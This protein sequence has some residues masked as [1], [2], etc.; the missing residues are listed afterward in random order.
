[1][2]YFTGKNAYFPFTQHFRRQ[3]AHESFFIFFNRGNHEPNSNTVVV[4]RPTQ[5][6]K[7]KQN[8]P[9]CRLTMTAN[10]SLSVFMWREQQNIQQKVEIIEISTKARDIVSV[11]SYIINVRKW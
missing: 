4:A 5:L 7:T 9:W 2:D 11:I 6:N 3:E 8:E 10:G 1:M